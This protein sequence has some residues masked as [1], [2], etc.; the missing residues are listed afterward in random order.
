VDPPYSPL[1]IPHPSFSSWQ[2]TGR[3]TNGNLALSADASGVITATRVSDGST[4]FT[5]A[6][7]S[8][9]PPAAGS[10]AGVS[11]ACLSL[12]LPG[13]NK[14]YGLGEHRTGLLD[15]SNYTKR[16]ET[17]QYY[18]VSHGA[19]IM[20]PFYTAFPLSVGLLWALPSYGNVSLAADGHTHTWC[21][22]ATANIDVWITTTPPV[23]PSPLNGDPAY[24][25]PLASLLN[26]FVDAVGHAAPMPPYVSGFWQC[27]NRYRDQ[28]QLLNVARGF[29]SRGLPLDII[30]I[31]YMH[32]LEFGD[33]SFNPGCW[34]SPA[35]MVT[36]LKDMGVE[37]AVTFWPYVTPSGAYFNNFTS[38]GYFA[39]A[40]NGSAMPVEDWAGPM[41]LVNEFSAAARAAIFEAFWEGYGKYGV[42]TIWLDGSEPERNKDNYGLVRFGE[43]GTDSELGEAWIQQHTLAF[44]EGFAARGFASDAFFL[45]PRSAWAGSS[46]YSAGVWSGDIQST[47]AELG[48]QVRV[49]QQMSLSGHALWTNDGGGYGGGDPSSPVFQE[50]VVRWLQASAFFPIMRLHGQRKGGPPKNQCGDTGGDNEPWTLAQDAQHYDAIAA[51]MNL[52]ASLKDYT[53]LLNG[54][55]V[56]TGMPMCRPM[57]MAFPDDPGVGGVDVEDQW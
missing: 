1:L 53:L 50:L 37:L 39:T 36:E 19:D 20:I 10:R 54:E 25:S 7:L 28:E 17:S 5:S 9:G 48:L 40:L 14:L 47:F 2:A 15:Q 16:L 24:T 43:Q 55:T 35:S 31:D 21:S 13:E 6:S 22:G 45:L 33:W 42:R 56:R 30:T 41:H 11:S 12:S 57:V 3:L 44:A 18:A 51:V 26:N 38:A 32:W 27:K 29:R 23:A 8:F 52:R 46:R 34:P 49:L 4:L